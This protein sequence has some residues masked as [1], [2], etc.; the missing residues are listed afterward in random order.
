MKKTGLIIALLFTGKVSAQ[1][2]PKID[3]WNPPVQKGISSLKVGDVMPE[4]KISRVFNDAKQAVRVSAYKDQLLI[5][6]FGNTGCSGCVAALPHMEKLQ[7]EFGNAV[8]IFWVTPEYEADVAAFW[9]KNRYVRGNTLAT[10]TEDSTLRAYFKHASWPHTAWIY[11]GKVIGITSPE[12]L[13]AVNISR[14]LKGAVMNWPVKDDFYY[15]DGTKETLFTI[16]EN[17]VAPGAVLDYAAISD[18]KEKDGASAAGVSGSGG[19]IRDSLKRTVRTWF[20]NQPVFSAYLQNW[21]KVLK[22]GSLVKPSV[23][24]QPNQIIWEVKD[25]KR[26]MHRSVATPGFNTGYMGDWMRGNAICFE[27]LHPD[28][29]QTEKDIARNIIAELDGLLGLKARWEKR[30][31]KVLVLVRSGKE[32]KFIKPSGLNDERPG[33]NQISYQM[34]LQ[35]GNPYVFDE[36][37]YNGAGRLD[38]Q[39]KSWTD[40]TSIKKAIAPYGLVF[41]EEERLVNKFIFTEIEGGLLAEK[42]VH[43]IKESQLEK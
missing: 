14:V 2:R 21:N 30:R 34:N 24:L 3:I 38:I 7:K 32:D 27:S 13:D 22:F 20:I 16:D 17:Q 40:I 33:V 18:Y 39:I 1:Q 15:F 26:Y 36:T 11:K 4:V 42:P 6:D 25:P 29:G 41:K 12:Y 31:E 28:T 43:T 23:M 10:I 5:L 37:K 35:A 19:I 9:K 8:K